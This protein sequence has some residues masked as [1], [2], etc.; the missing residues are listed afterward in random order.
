MVSVFGANRYFLRY[1]LSRFVSRIGDGIHSLVLLWISYK[2]SHSG[3]VVALVMIS[4]SLPAVLV[5]PFA[6]SLADRKNRAK[7]MAATDIIQA[8]CTF[9]LALLAYYHKLNLFYLMFLRRLCPLQAPILCR[10][11]CP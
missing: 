9:T 4:F 3:L 8:F 6:G 7:I 5:F 2:W 1:F 10:H 11:R